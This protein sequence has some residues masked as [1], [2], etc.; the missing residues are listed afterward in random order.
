[1]METRTQ[2]RI[3]FLWSVGKIDGSLTGA[4][5]R[6]SPRTLRLLSR[7][8][9]RKN[10]NLDQARKRKTQRHWLHLYAATPKKVVA[11][12]KMMA[13]R[14]R[15]KRK[16]KRGGS[17]ALLPSC[18]PLPQIRTERKAR[19]RARSKNST[20]STCLYVSCSLGRQ[21]TLQ[22]S[23]GQLKTPRKRWRLGWTATCFSG[24]STCIPKAVRVVRTSH[25]QTLRGNRL[26]FYAETACNPH[27]ATTRAIP[28]RAQA[29]ALLRAA[30][31]ARPTSV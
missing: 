6:R 1:M 17:P 3:P 12:K 8:K 23:F 14:R 2:I 19:L 29:T 13:T 21:L 4:A 26:S 22:R 10:R 15:R 30:S 11:L 24:F 9:I 31:K 20:T 16:R 25:A 5:E 27:L 28:A 7:K 18:L